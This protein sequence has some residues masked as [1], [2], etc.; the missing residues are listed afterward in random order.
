[1]EEIT[2][3]SSRDWARTDNIKINPKETG[4]KGVSQ[5][6][7]PIDKDKQRV[8]EFSGFLVANIP[9]ISHIKTKLSLSIFF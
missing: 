9:S 4:Y 6:C 7:F 5:N 8:C 1:M 3:G 2:V